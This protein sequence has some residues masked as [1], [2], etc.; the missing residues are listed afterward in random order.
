MRHIFVSVFRGD[1]V[2]FELGRTF[3]SLCFCVLLVSGRLRLC[4]GHH[5]WGNDS[6]NNKKEYQAEA[7]CV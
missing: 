4:L 1:A 5:C 6:I 2:F 7:L 3:Y